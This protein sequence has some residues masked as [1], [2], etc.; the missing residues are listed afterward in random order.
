[1]PRAYQA[2]CRKLDL[3]NRDDVAQHVIELA[4]TGRCNPTALYW[5]TVKE[6]QERVR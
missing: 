6:F 1:M 4:Q 5:L 2:A 3:A